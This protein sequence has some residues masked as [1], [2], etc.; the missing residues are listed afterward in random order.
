MDD[1]RGALIGRI[2]WY[3]DGRR[4]N[5]GRV[6]KEGSCLGFEGKKQPKYLVYCLDSCFSKEKCLIEV[7]ELYDT[8]EEVYDSLIETIKREKEAVVKR[9]AKKE[10]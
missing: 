3:I 10:D 9:C 1:E 5:E 2:I 6:I 4:V 8:P 7:F